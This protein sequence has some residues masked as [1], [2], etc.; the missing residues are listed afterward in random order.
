[1]R[2][3]TTA[4]PSRFPGCCSTLLWDASL[5]ATEEGN[6]KSKSK[7]KDWRAKEK[8]KD[9][10]TEEACSGLMEINR[11]EN[12]PEFV[13]LEAQGVRLLWPA[14]TSQ[15][16]IWK[17]EQSFPGKML[18]SDRGLGHDCEVQ[19]TTLCSR[20]GEDALVTSVRSASKSVGGPNSLWAVPSLRTGPWL[21]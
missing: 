3:W 21:Y 10:V 16:L 19:A 20:Q 15:G 17:E 14:G 9:T 7:G 13:P 6:P 2:A 1:M 4:I 5:E 11:T 18:P 8:L 12:E